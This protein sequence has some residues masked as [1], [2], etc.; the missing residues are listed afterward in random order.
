MPRPVDVRA[1]LLRALELDLVGPTKGS[2]LEEEVLPQAPSRWYLTGFLVP[3]DT[4]EEQRAEE[5]SRE[6]VDELTD[7]GG[8]DDAA[9]PEPASA[10]RIFYPSSIGM[11]FLVGPATRKLRATV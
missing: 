6:E 2:P 10:R 7:S 3:T 4:G 9:A 11:S 5:T 8:T 1:D